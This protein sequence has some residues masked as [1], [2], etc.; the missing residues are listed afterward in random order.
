MYP[1]NFTVHMMWC[2]LSSIFC[3]WVIRLRFAVYL[4]FMPFRFPLSLQLLPCIWHGAFGHPYLL[5]GQ[6]GAT[7]PFIFWSLCRYAICLSNI[8]VRMTWYILSSIF[9]GGGI[10]LHFA[11]CLLISMPLCNLSAKFYCGYDVVR[12]AS[13]ISRRGNSAPLCRL[14]ANLYAALQFYFQILQHIWHGAFYL[15]YCGGVIR[16]RFPIYLLIAMP[17]C[18]LSSNVYLAYDMVHFIFHIFV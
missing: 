3:C 13:R 2:I 10:R 17:L 7:L 9:R 16:L 15:P 11:V 12:F 5:E 1:P 18:N 4:L 14:S 6:F 8:T